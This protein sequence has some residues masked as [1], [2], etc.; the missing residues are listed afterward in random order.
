ML[1]I[2]VCREI[3]VFSSV[4]IVNHW[5]PKI[6]KP[7]KNHRCRWLIPP[8]TIDGDGKKFSKTIA[9]PSLG[10]YDHHHS[11]ATKNWPSFQ[12]MFKPLWIRYKRGA[13]M[14]AM[15]RSML[16]NE[17]LLQSITSYLTTYAHSTVITSDLFN[18]LEKPAKKLGVVPANSRLWDFMEPWITRPGFPVVYLS[19]NMADNSVWNMATIKHIY[20]VK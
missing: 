5:F 15:L 16:G 8:K 20:N 1:W 13:C 9:I 12:S 18:V 3:R 17:V 6:A 14:M 4:T 2:W 19:R 11:I 10:K 7:S